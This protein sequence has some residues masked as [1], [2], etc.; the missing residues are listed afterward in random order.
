M[1]TIREELVLVDKFSKVLKS[2]IT[3]ADKASQSTS[4]AKSTIDKF[5]SA[6]IAGSK[7]VSSLTNAVTSL[8]GAYLGIQ[9]LR[10]VLN[11]SD[12]LSQTTARLD[13][14]NDG[15]QTAEELTNMIYAAAQRSRGSFTQTAN[16]VGQL[17][18]LAG[19]AFN[20]TQELVAFAEQ[21][22]KQIALSGASAMAADAAVLQLTQ[23]LSSGAL[24]GE[25][26]NSVLEQTPTVAQT[27]ADYLG[28]TTGKMREMA[29]EGALTAE[30]VKNA[31]L[32]AADETNAKFASMPMTFAQNM[33]QLQN[34]AIMAFQ[35]VLQ[36][37]NNFLNSPVFEQVKINLANAITAIATFAQQALM[38]IGN[39]INWVAQNWSVIQPILAGVV[40]AL[41]A[42]KTVTLLVAAAQAILNMVLMA[43]PLTWIILVIAIII[44]LIAMWIS[45]VGGLQVAWLIVV[46]AILL[47]WDYL[48]LGFWTGVF[49]VQD[50][51]ASMALGFQQAGV[52]IANFVGQMKVT[53]LSIIQNMVN[54]AIDLINWFI[55]QLNKL[56]GVS[57]SAIGH[58][59]FAATAAAEEAAASASREAGLAAQAEANAAQKAQHQA[60]L[61]QMMNDLMAN[62]AS[63]QDEIAQLQHAS[64]SEDN[65]SSLLDMLNGTGDM[66]ALTGLGDLG[67]LGGLGGSGG[68]GGLGGVGGGSGGV[69]G[70]SDSV[71]SSLGSDVADIKKEVSM[72]EEDLKSLV[73][74]AERQ[75]VNEINLTAQTPVINVNGQNTGNSKE[76]RKALANAIRDILVE[77]ASSASF[78]STARTV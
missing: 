58:V 14:M 8:A 67:S 29:S 19:D 25:E 47:A 50:M 20:S 39:V 73:D 45:Y 62:H 36:S 54:G 41:I 27:I 64:Q 38:V 13:M 63:R 57:I 74:M 70:I 9:G 4:K 69:G 26:L 12:T 10:N 52:A 33:Q 35:P 24:R 78:K 42:W 59:T 23:G 31:L 49:W 61:D 43:S 32:S 18:N 37:I 28:V 30:V 44:G 55:E 11:L 71:G 72:S 21:L 5:R 34:Y 68:L 16:M 2:Y 56:P 15:L 60:Q 48:V 22:N 75:Y 66:G 3:G 6:S 46:D 53:V 1:A 76:D 17:G 51:L 77:Q 7:G 65:T 40:A